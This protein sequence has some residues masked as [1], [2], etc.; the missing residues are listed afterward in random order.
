MV[1]NGFGKE[2]LD[3]PPSF[4]DKEREYKVKRGSYYT[5]TKQYDGKGNLEKEIWEREDS[6][7]KEI[8][9]EDAA[10]ISQEKQDELKKLMKADQKNDPRKYTSLDLVKLAKKEKYTG[11]N[12]LIA[13]SYKGELYW[14]SRVTSIDPSFEE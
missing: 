11:P 2:S 14:S 6:H 4:G 10:Y 12:G 7:K 9:L 1:L 13:F 3:I 8:T 5:Q